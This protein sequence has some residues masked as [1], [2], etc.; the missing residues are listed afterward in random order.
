MLMMVL[1]ILNINLI[2]TDN[3][4]I[5]NCATIVQCSALQHL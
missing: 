1:E 3:L 2:E 4:N 5:E